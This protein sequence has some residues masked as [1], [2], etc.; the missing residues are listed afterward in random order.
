MY[1][2]WTGSSAVFPDPFLI[3]PWTPP[4]PHPSAPFTPSPPSATLLRRPPERTL[5]SRRAHPGPSLP[6]RDATATRDIASEIHSRSSRGRRTVFCDSS[7]SLSTS[8][9]AQRQHF[10][11]LRPLSLNVSSLPASVS[12][13]PAQ[14]P[15]KELN[16]NLPLKSIVISPPPSLNRSFSEKGKAKNTDKQTA[17]N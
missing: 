11:P 5:T 12:F 1:N 15:S 8:V 2:S 9:H 6:S 3:L 14:N 4:T 10:S 13:S 16:F 17:N 7:L